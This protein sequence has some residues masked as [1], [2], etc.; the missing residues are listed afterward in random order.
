MV[1]HKEIFTFLAGQPYKLRIGAAGTKG[2]AGGF[3]G[4]GAGGSGNGLGGGGGGYTGLFIDS[5]SQANTILLLVVWRW[6][7]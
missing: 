1:Q 4:G 2:G 5:I 6:F 3:P 7:Q